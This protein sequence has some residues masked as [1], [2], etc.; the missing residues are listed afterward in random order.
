MNK[1]F[2]LLY[3]RILAANK[4]ISNDE[5]ISKLSNIRGNLITIGTGGS[6][7]TAYYASKL[8]EGNN[9]FS[10]NMYPRDLIYCNSDNIDNIMAFSYSGKTPS[11]IQALNNKKD[12]TKTIVT[13]NKLYISENIENVLNYGNELEQEKSFISIAST[14]I[15]MTLLLRYCHNLTYYEMATLI[16]DIIDESANLANNVDNNI[17]S[18]NTVEIMSGDNTYSAGYILQSAFNESG[19]GYPL[20]YEKNNY[21]HGCATLNYHNN[22]SLLIYLLNT[23]TEQD[24]IM[25][26]EVIPTYENKVII[27]AKYKDKI[28]EL[29][30]AIKSLFLLKKIAE[31]KKV[32]LS[33][34]DYP[35]H[36]KKIYSFNGGM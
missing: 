4:R 12:I 16:R 14:I 35:K 13:G 1:N 21:A 24:E 20:V 23:K 34:I 11:I 32:N 8:F 6:Y 18:G 17:L 28:G 3:E 10:K 36:I 27:S 33:A 2:E 15:P 5:L 22:T 26:S 9:C 19:M 30:L 29:E 31:Q 7:P 25:I